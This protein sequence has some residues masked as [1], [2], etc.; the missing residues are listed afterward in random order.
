MCLGVLHVTKGLFYAKTLLNFDGTP[1]RFAV[2]ATKGGRYH[3]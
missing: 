2:L 1:G 3:I